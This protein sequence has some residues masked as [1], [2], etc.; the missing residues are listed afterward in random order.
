M[1]EHLIR[2]VPR[3]DIKGP[4]VV[5]GINFEGLRVMGKP[6][7]F[8]KFYYENGADE[9]IYMDVVASLYGRNNLFNIVEKVSKEIFVPLIVGGGI[10]NLDDMQKLLMVGADRISINTMAINN[11]E[12]ISEAANKFGISTIVI[13]IEAIKDKNGKYEAY[14]NNGRERTGVDVFEWAKRV[15]ELG[16][17]EILLTS[18]DNEG[19]GKGFDIDLIRKV[20]ESISIPVIAA[21]GAGKMEHV[22]EVVIDGKANAVCVAS[23]LHYKTIEV[24][25]GEDDYSD[26]GNTTY[27][28]SKR[29]FSKINGV[30]IKKIKEY[31]YNNKI[32]CR[33]T[34]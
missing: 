13:S 11:P 14:T 16:A 23:M 7:N 3:L 6:E 2:I 30:E 9:I 20:S 31:L 34:R 28:K 24:D 32:N 18:I 1:M 17:G 22:K 29:K 27:L 4:N 21:G 26:E 19:T 25:F 8:A 5:K 15:A 12:L 10:R 33:L